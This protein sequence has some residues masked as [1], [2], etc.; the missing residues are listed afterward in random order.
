MHHTSLAIPPTALHR[1]QILAQIPIWIPNMTTV[2]REGLGLYLES[3]KIPEL[4]INLAYLA[5]SMNTAMGRTGAMMTEA[6][7]EAVTSRR[8]LSGRDEKVGTHMRGC[9]RGGM[10]DKAGK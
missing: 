7:A 3:G 10:R 2:G 1:A 8:E 6:E 5:I 4:R 9:R